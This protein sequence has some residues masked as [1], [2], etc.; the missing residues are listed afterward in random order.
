MPSLSVRLFLL[1]KDFHAMMPFR[2]N[3]HKLSVAV[4]ICL[5]TVCVL[6]ARNTDA[7]DAHDE[8]M[9]IMRASDAVSSLDRSQASTER[10]RA[11]ARLVP[12]LND[13]ADMLASNRLDPKGSMKMAALKAC[14][15]AAERYSEE[16]PEALARTLYN[17][18]NLQGSYYDSA[19]IPTIERAISLVDGIA[20]AEES[21]LL[22]KIAR[23]HLLYSYVEGESPMRIREIFGLEKDFLGFYKSHP[24]TVS[25][26]E[27]MHMLA[28]MK[29][30][31]EFDND[32]KQA[33]DSVLFADKDIDTTHYDIIPFTGIITNSPYY[34][35]ESLAIL[36]RLLGNDSPDTMVPW[37]NC[38]M[39]G[40]MPG[41]GAALVAAADSVVAI[42]ESK[43]PQGHPMI[44]DMKAIRDYI[45][46]T[47]G[48][49]LRFD[50]KYAGELEPYAGYYGAGSR[51]YLSLPV[52]YGLN[53]GMAAGAS[54]VADVM[55][56]EQIYDATARIT[57]ADD[58]GQYIMDKMCFMQA[59]EKSDVTTLASRLQELTA[60]ALDRRLK[61]SWRLFAAAR[62][63]AQACNRNG[64]TQDALAITRRLAGDLD[65]LTGGKA[66]P[67]TADIQLETAGYAQYYSQSADT[68]RREYDKT[69]KLYAEVGIPPT[70][71]LLNYGLYL[72]SIGDYDGAIRQFDALLKLDALRNL[73][74]DR[75]YTR[76]LLGQSMLNAHITDTA[77]LADVFGEAEKLYMAD[78]VDLNSETVRG[79]MLLAHYYNYLNRHDLTE[80]ALRKGWELASQL[81]EPLDATLFDFN[82]ELFSLYFFQGNDHEA[83]L[84]NEQNI[85]AIE[86]AGLQES[87]LY[88]EALWNR[89][90][91][92]N[93]R[94]PNDLLQ[95]LPAVM[96]QIP[97][98]ASV[99]ERTGQ[100]PDILYNYALRILTVALD[101]AAEGKTQMDSSAEEYGKTSEKA[102]EYR[103]GKEFFYRMMSM[104]KEQALP[105]MHKIEKDFPEYVKPYDYRATPTWLSIVSSLMKWYG[106][107]E[108]DKQ[109]ELHYLNLMAEAYTASG[110]PWQADNAMAEYYIRESNWQKAY[111]HTQ[112]CCQH[113]DRFS[114]FEKLQIGD[115]MAFLANTLHHDDEAVE[116]AVAQAGR[117]RSYVLANFDF[118]SSNERAEFLNSYGNTGIRLNDML[119]RRPAELAADVYNAALFDKGLLLH[120]WE[121]L[122]R[123]ILRSGDKA[124]A[125]KLDTLDM[126]NK[127]KRAMSMDMT[128]S[129]SSWAHAKMQR[130]IDRLEKWLS[131]QTVKFR[132]DTMRV[133][134]WQDVRSSLKDKEAAVEF[135]LGDSSLMALVVRPGCERPRYVRLCN[136]AEC[137]ETL[138]R[139][140]NFPAETRARRLYTYGRSRLYDMIWAP[141]AGELEGIKTVYYSPTAF[142]NR[143]AF[144]ALPVSADSCLADCY[145]LHQLSTT[146]LL[147]AR[148]RTGKISSAALFGGINYGNMPESMTQNADGSRAALSVAFAD[149]TETRAETDTIAENM[150]AGGIAIDKYMGDNATEANFYALDGNS[151]GIIHLATHG[152]Y[153]SE[154]NV[155]SNAFLK[156]HPGGRYH[157][158]QRSGLAFAGANATWMGEKKPDGNDGIM[159]ANELSMLDLS[160]TDLV[161]LSACETALGDYSLEGVYGLQRG[162]K[163]AG[164]RS[165][166]LSLWNVNDRATSLFM[167]DFYRL[168]LGGRSKHEAF[169]LAVANLRA[170]HPSPFF[171]AAFV[172]LDAE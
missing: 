105:L 53:L 136:A 114:T 165:M 111:E 148:G 137:Y 166:I 156:N 102:A 121:R 112:R 72:N 80:K 123:S 150:T 51:A 108:A 13:Y 70:M 124:L 87:A 110:T 83:E 54:S 139:V 17:L 31:T 39:A 115:R 126:L 61:P 94:T 15:D 168:W 62:R 159:T 30:R 144:A 131:R 167:Q 40:A 141:L 143:V 41:D 28:I 59:Y 88:L 55:K 153:I 19:C 37:I 60:M 127:Q 64:R 82:N 84:F 118:M 58:P 89:F 92:I 36:R 47:N 52:I 6:H 145:D 85:A 107:V 77:R 160:R 42:T 67:I 163:E 71:P 81:C 35:R 132:A 120:S 57:Y 16:C 113:I 117:I 9:L 56:M 99:Y 164:V 169:S 155:E 45:A 91:I 158:M 75:A 24:E 48:Y 142:L 23:Q 29:E 172:L 106:K 157:S 25:K 27:M 125:A 66:L 26:A 50:W 135:V 133:V 74:Y 103:K 78:T 5:A 3:L 12:V 147:A 170:T 14:A 21:Q 138:S 10:I 90:I 2:I 69:L 100:S 122:R 162:F 8:A 151:P 1:T 18:A 7:T 154:K 93:W 86:A 49:P 109:L 130:S 96:E 63:L 149:L 68:I 161:V 140:D 95:Y 33:T 32:F 134:S 146:A 152:F 22:Y 128:D 20:T 46:A 34:Y 101:A 79:Y 116:T 97:I 65:V 98:I 43:M 38:L 171:W 104:F 129:A 44:T 119:S 11:A 76:L 73:P 4:L